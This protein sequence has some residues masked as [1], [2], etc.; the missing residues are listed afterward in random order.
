MASYDVTE[1]LMIDRPHDSMSRA[2]RQSE[3]VK[4]LILEYNIESRS[5]KSTRKY[6]KPEAMYIN[7]R[8]RGSEEVKL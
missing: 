4:I 1:V 7:S 6:K 2:E 5:T 3:Q 8:G